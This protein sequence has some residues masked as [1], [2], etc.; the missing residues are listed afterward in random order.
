MKACTIIVSTASY[1]IFPCWDIGRPSLSAQNSN[2][3]SPRVRARLIIWKDAAC[4]LSKCAMRNEPNFNLSL[5]SYCVSLNRFRSWLSPCSTRLLSR[6][7]T[8]LRLR[9][10]WFSL[11]R[12]NWFSALFSSLSPL[13]LLSRYALSRTC[14]AEIRF[15]SI[16]MVFGKILQ[17]SSISLFLAGISCRNSFPNQTSGSVAYTFL[18]CCLT[19]FFCPFSFS[20]QQVQYVRAAPQVQMIAQAPAPIQ[21]VLTFMFFCTRCAALYA[22][23]VAM[24][25]GS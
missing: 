25:S 8:L 13:R 3:A 17:M 1:C 19:L 14:F 7:P 18:T 20:K 16:F 21:Q 9:P 2:F 4:D 6:R 24:H 23:K 5:S 22:G 11:S 15:G 10:P 12:S